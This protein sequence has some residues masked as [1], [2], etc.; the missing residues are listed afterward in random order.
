M[1]GR[2]LHTLFEDFW[3]FLALRRKKKKSTWSKGPCH[4]RVSYRSLK[5][6]LEGGKLEMFAICIA[7]YGPIMKLLVPPQQLQLLPAMITTRVR[8][9]YWRL[10]SSQLLVSSAAVQPFVEHLV[11]AGASLTAL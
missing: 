5:R 1:T 8:M 9:N 4:S 11:F 10:P 3:I 6:L 2:A 7:L